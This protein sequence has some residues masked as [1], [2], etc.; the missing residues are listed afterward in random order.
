MSSWLEL[1]EKYKRREM[2]EKINY[3]VIQL[4]ESGLTYNQLSALDRLGRK[5]NFDMVL[6]FIIGL[7]YGGVFGYLIGFGV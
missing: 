4:L 2:D 6:I 1:Y 3:E 7:I 5:H